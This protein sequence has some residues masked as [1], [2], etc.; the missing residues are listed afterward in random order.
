MDK[1]ILEKKVTFYNAQDGIKKTIKSFALTLGELKED[2]INHNL[3]FNGESQKIIV[4]ALDESIVNNS[5]ESDSSS[6]PNTD[7][8]AMVFNKESKAGAGISR[9]EIYAQ[10]N[11]HL[12]GKMDEERRQL[13]NY[14]SEGAP[15]WTNVSSTLLLERLQ[16]LESKVVEDTDL[17]EE[18]AS[19]MK[20][21]I[22]SN[23][24]N[25]GVIC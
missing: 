11:E 22:C 14:F 16:A 18:V 3:S 10:I 12:N 23:A 20:D 9:K 2:F 24:R 4:T 21:E 15:H 25:I 8:I 5:I 1:L 17:V 6:V 7:Y 19:R 13:L